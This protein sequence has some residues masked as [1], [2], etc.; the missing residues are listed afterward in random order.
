MDTVGPDQHVADGVG[1][2]LEYGPDSISDLFDIDQAFAV[3][4]GDAAGGGLLVDR[5]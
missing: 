4:D 3:L 2:V 5:L 1:A